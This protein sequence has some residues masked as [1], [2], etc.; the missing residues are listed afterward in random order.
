M[1]KKKPQ[2]T[3]LE[4]FQLANSIELFLAKPW[5]S[6]DAWQEVV[7]N[8]F[9]FMIMMKKYSDHLE[10]INNN[11]KNLHESENPAC[12][13]STNFNVRFISKCNKR[14]INSRY[15]SLDSDLINREL[16]N[17]VDFDLYI[18]ND[19]IKKYNFIHEIQLSMPAGLYR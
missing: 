17:F 5:A 14:E 19:L 6:K 12:E 3:C 9:E 18:S 7:L 2:L 10:I 11:M 1:K 15:H 4:L 16:F 13:P 8:I